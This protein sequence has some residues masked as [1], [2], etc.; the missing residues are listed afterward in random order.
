MRYRGAQV[1]LKLPAE[2]INKLIDHGANLIRYQMYVPEAEVK[3]IEEW[4]SEIESYLAHLESILPEINPKGR[5]IV[6]MHTPPLGMRAS[7]AVIFKNPAAYNALIEMWA[8]IA[9]RFKASPVF[10]YGILNEPAGPSNRVFQ[11]MEDAARRIRREGE[12]D[13]IV[14]ISSPGASPHGFEGYVPDSVDLN[15][16]HEAHMYWPFSIS[17]QGINRP[18]GRQY[19]N[20][21]VNKEV[22]RAHL[23]DLKDFAV[24]YRTHIYIGEFGCSVFADKETRN[25][26][27]RHIMDICEVYHWSYTYHAW[28]EAPVWDPIAEPELDENGDESDQP[29]VI[30]TLESFWKKNK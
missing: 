30:K 23:S 10:G 12:K 29:S 7:R 25:T 28:D 20:E 21:K 4:Q 17:H 3:T 22:L 26:Y 2:S 8:A 18:D 16:W 14:C 13:K 24:K 27:L 6:D 11:L 15:R 9:I 5:I 19:P 1:G